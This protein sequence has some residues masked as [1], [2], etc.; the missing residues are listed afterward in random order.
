M[1]AGKARPVS[2]GAVRKA[3]CFVT[4]IAVVRSLM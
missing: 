2:P 4:C 3:Y 1:R